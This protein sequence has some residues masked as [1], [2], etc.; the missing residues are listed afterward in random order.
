MYAESRTG[1]MYFYLTVFLHVRFRHK[2]MRQIDGLIGRLTAVAASALS[3]I[4]FGRLPGSHARSGGLSGGRSGA[5]GETPYDLP[6]QRYRNGDS[7]P[8]ALRRLCDVAHIARPALGL[9]AGYRAVA[10]LPAHA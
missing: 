8:G 10:F 1:R 5:A 3:V 7:G 2:Q 9:C 4:R 6:D